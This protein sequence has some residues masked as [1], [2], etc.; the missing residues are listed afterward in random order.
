MMKTKCS[1]VHG[2]AVKIEMPKAKWMERS[3]PG[4]SQTLTGNSL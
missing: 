1:V 2:S 4:Q 3:L